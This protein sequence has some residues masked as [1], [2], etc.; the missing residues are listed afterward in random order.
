MLTTLDYREFRNI[1]PKP[2]PGMNASFN[3]PAM[4]TRA[5][6]ALRSA[7]LSLRT[8]GSET[9]SQSGGTDSYFWVEYTTSLLDQSFGHGFDLSWEQVLAGNIMAWIA[10]STYSGEVKT[11]EYFELSFACLSFALTY[12]VLFLS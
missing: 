3:S 9:C 6:T 7:I 2:L 11:S 10:Y 8:H 5:T 12:S 4:D 1:D